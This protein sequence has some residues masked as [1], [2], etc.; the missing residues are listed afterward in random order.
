MQNVDKCCSDGKRAKYSSLHRLSR[1]LEYVI[2]NKIEEKESWEEKTL[3]IYQSVGGL[4][5]VTETAWKLGPEIVLKGFFL[6]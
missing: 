2:T 4:G 6:I 3:P 5:D 1:K